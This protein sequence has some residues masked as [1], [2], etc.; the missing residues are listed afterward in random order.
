M[1]SIVTPSRIEVVGKWT[2]A[3]PNISKTREN[4][5][6]TKQKAN[7]LELDG[8]Q[9]LCKDVRTLQVSFNRPNCKEIHSNLRGGSEKHTSQ[10]RK[11]S[12]AVQKTVTKLV[13][14]IKTLFRSVEAKPNRDTS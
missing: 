4:L 14:V 8:R 6:A 1:G 9:T 13:G 7:S 5:P 12:R 10:F 11:D 3:D 2:K